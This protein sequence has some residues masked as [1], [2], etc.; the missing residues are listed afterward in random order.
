MSLKLPFLVCIWTFPQKN[1]EEI[2]D[3]HEERFH[4]DIV[5][6]EKSRKWNENILTDYCWTLIREA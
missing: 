3:E 4:M 1:I 2:S 6:M 5:K